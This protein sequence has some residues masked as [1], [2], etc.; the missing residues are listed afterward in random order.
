M[1]GGVVPSLSCTHDRI[2]AMSGKDRVWV[3]KANQGL[4]C[5]PGDRKVLKEGKVKQT[6]PIQLQSLRPWRG[7]MTRSSLFGLVT[8]PS[9]LWTHV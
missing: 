3:V 8:W 2:S 5:L 9:P 4:R 1:A 7:G 6:G